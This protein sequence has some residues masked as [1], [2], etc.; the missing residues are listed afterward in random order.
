MRN[1]FRFHF[2]WLF[3]IGW[4]G[5]N[6]R[7]QSIIPAVA[8]AGGTIHQNYT[9]RYCI[10][11]PDSNYFF[12]NHSEPEYPQKE[13]QASQLLEIRCSCKNQ[14]PD[15][16]WLLTVNHSKLIEGEYRNGQRT[17]EWWL[18]TGSSDWIF[19]RVSFQNDTII[20]HMT[21]TYANGKPAGIWPYKNNL[22]DGTV[23]VWD[24]LGNKIADVEYKEGLRH[25]EK[26]IYDTRTGKLLSIEEWYNDRMISER[27]IK[28]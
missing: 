23:T 12:T 3:L 26:H 18:Y 2:T 17:G 21:A 20:N 1:R 19:A 24:L 11:K 27:D 28:N 5:I 4:A 25:G 10:G 14:K 15:G 13:V 22:L 9:F 16:H 8:L 7:A 6:L